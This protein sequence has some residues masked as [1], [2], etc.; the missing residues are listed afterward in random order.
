MVTEE[1]DVSAKALYDDIVGYVLRGLCK[2]EGRYGEFIRA[3][4]ELIDKM[5]EYFEVHEREN[6]PRDTEG[7]KT[8][9]TFYDLFL[10]L[11]VVEHR[12]MRVT[13]DEM[14]S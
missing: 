7:F 12:V 3:R 13:L 8:L 6:L 10:E 9:A 5:R 14:N 1:I 2:G 4:N 11:F